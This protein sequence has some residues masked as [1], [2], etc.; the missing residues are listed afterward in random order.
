[1]DV[2][3]LTAA[4]QLQLSVNPGCVSSLVYSAKYLP[5]DSP[6][7]Q[8]FSSPPLGPFFNFKLSD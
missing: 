4:E 6:P 2:K 1:M 3:E 7:Q 8:E 5:R